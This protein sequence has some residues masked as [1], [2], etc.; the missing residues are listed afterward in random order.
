VE[1]GYYLLQMGKYTAAEVVFHCH[2]DQGELAWAI[3]IGNEVKEALLEV[4][5]ISHYFLSTTYD[6]LTGLVRPEH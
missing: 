6:P 2:R 5:W 4:Q 1:A 3:I